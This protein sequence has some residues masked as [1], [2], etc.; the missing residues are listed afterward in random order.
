MKS[1]QF[2]LQT[3]DGSSVVGGVTQI[4]IVKLWLHNNNGQAQFFFLW[5]FFI[6]VSIPFARLSFYGLLL[7]G[8]LSISSRW[9]K[10]KF[11]FRAALHFDYDRN[12]HNR[13]I[14]T[15]ERPLSTL[16]KNVDYTCGELSV[17]YANRRD[18]KVWTESGYCRRFWDWCFIIRK[19]NIRS[20]RTQKIP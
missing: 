11:F 17:N 19:N 14:S 3:G 13:N 10:E 1:V 12:S 18:L 15:K 8:S 4:L 20:A 5:F 6:C 7:G 9:R 2:E 16:V